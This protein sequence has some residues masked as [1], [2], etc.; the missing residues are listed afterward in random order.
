MSVTTVVYCN[1][2]EAGM[3]DMMWSKLIRNSRKDESNSSPYRSFHYQILSA[4]FIYRTSYFFKGID[5][6]TPDMIT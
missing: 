6:I 4:S 5:L 3:I 2:N 1:K